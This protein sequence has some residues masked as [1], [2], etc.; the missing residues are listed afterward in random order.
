MTWTY[1]PNPPQPPPPSPK[2]KQNKNKL[3]FVKY[4]VNKIGNFET[5]FKIDKML[6]QILA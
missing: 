3:N 1:G 2:K 6:S 4:Q 5:K